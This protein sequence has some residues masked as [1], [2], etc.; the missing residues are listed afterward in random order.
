MLHLSQGALLSALERR[1]RP[2]WVAA[3]TG[4]RSQARVI[5][6]N[7]TLREIKQECRRKGSGSHSDSDAWFRVAAMATRIERQSILGLESATMAKVEAASVQSV[8]LLC[9]RGVDSAAAAGV[10]LQA[11][12]PNV[13][14][15][16]GGLDAW[17]SQVDPNF[18]EY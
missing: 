12:A 3:L 2:E 13:V 14:N 17:R 15:I 6:A 1:G 9:R 10:L 11:G 16:S 4:Q 7:I 8:F 18:P 5:I